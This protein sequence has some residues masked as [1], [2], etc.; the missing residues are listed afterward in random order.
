MRTATI[1]TGIVTA[2]VLGLLIG[3]S[4]PRHAP[5]ISTEVAPPT[6]S[7][8]NKVQ[9]PERYGI[10][11][12][13]QLGR[14]GFPHAPMTFDFLELKAMLE[15]DLGLSCEITGDELFARD[16]VDVLK[17][18]RRGGVIVESSYA[19]DAEIWGADEQQDAF[20]R[21]FRMLRVCCG[22]MNVP[23]TVGV[24]LINAALFEPAIDGHDAMSFYD[25]MINAWDMGGTILFAINVRDD[26]T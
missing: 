3:W 10:S 6:T 12:L 11:R 26:A 14:Q 22:V 17:F 1:T 21:Q 8:S 16:R 18:R 2:L 15:I 20:V 13:M 9:M 24:R 25:K 19:T 7:E 5:T 23:A 4:V